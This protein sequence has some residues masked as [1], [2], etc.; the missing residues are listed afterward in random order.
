MSGQDFATSLLSSFLFFLVGWRFFLHGH[1]FACHCVYLHFGDVLEW[2]VAM[3]NDQTSFP[4]S[5][6]IQPSLILP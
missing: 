6:P 4:F 3:S 2:G 5:S 1:D